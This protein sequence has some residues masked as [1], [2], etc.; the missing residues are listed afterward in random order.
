MSNWVTVHS[1]TEKYVEIVSTPTN[2]KVK[3]A[4]VSQIALKG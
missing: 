3:L 1:Q 2:G 4:R